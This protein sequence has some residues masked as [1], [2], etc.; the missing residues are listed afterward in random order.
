[1]YANMRVRA[2]SKMCVHLPAVRGVG[3]RAVVTVGTSAR[4]FA[5]GIGIVKVALQ[6]TNGE[7]ALAFECVVESN[8]DS[9]HPDS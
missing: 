7:T 1:M 4:V 6:E 5:P 9:M 2:F 3:T 8:G